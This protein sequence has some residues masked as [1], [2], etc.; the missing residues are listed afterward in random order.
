MTKYYKLL[1]SFHDQVGVA[2][3]KDNGRAVVV[4][5]DRIIIFT[6]LLDKDRENE[7]TEKEFNRYKIAVKKKINNELKQL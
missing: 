5:K 3:E 2:A 1:S 7:T 4:M 6:S